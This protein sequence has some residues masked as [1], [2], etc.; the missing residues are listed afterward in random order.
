LRPPFALAGIVWL[1]DAPYRPGDRGGPWL[2][3]ESP[4]FASV[5]SNTC[6]QF[7]RINVITVPVRTCDM[8]D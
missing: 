6:G 1:A 5:T 2:K 8:G 7:L 3:S 4:F